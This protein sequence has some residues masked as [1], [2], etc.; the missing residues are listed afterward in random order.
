[1]IYLDSCIV[2]DLVEEHP[3]YAP[4][5]EAALVEGET[6]CISPLVEMECLV[7][8]LQHQRNDLLAKFQRFFSTQCQL[9]LPGAIFH[10]AAEL[11][12]RHG[13][14]TPDALHLAAARHHQCTEPGTN[15]DRLKVV[16]GTLAVNVLTRAT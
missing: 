1:M 6:Y 16:A 13:L 4:S 11:R 3:A 12:A 2:T 9:D 7:L 10:A 14:K 8:P 15:D 5:I